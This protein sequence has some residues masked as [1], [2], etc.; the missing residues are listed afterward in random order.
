MLLR[1]MVVIPCSQESEKEQ[2]KEMIFIMKWLPQVWLTSERE[3]HVVLL[4]MVK[5]TSL[6]V[7]EQE[8]D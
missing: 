4:F 7:Q 5:W 3:D 2:E 1:L 8:L 6:Q